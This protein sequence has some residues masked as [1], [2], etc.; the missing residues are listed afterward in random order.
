MPVWGNRMVVGTAN[1]NHRRNFDEDMEA[2]YRK[3]EEW[4]NKIK[5][6]RVQNLYNNTNKRGVSY[7]QFT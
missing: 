2:R 3:I 1:H 5:P 6:E 4:N 7:I